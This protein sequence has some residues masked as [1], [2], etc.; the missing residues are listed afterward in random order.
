MVHF[1]FVAYGVQNC[2]V[3][4]LVEVVGATNNDKDHIQ[5]VICF[6]HISQIKYLLFSN[7]L[8]ILQLL[9]VEVNELFGIILLVNLIEYLPRGVE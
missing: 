7:G 3:A 2:A 5:K 1:H 9:T 8:C 4:I 6:D